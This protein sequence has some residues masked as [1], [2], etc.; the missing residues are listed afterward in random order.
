MI[1]STSNDVG[2]TPVRKLCTL[3]LACALAMA[4]CDTGGEP[5]ASDPFATPT[6]HVTSTS[7]TV[8]A[9]TT[10]L[11]EPE[12]MSAPFNLDYRQ[13]PIGSPTQ[14]WQVPIVLNN[15]DVNSRLIMEQFLVA[16]LSQRARDQFLLRGEIPPAR[17]VPTVEEVKALK[18]EIDA[19][20][21]VLHNFFYPINHPDYEEDVGFPTH[22]GVSPPTDVDLNQ[23]LALRRDPEPNSK[24][25]ILCCTDQ[26]FRFEVSDTGALQVFESSNY[27]ADVASQ[28]LGV[29][30]EL[31]SVTDSSGSHFTLTA[32]TERISYKFSDP[33]Q[34]TMDTAFFSAGGTVEVGGILSPPPSD[35]SLLFIYDCRAI[36]YQSW[37]PDDCEREHRKQCDAEMIV[38][39]F[40]A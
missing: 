7:S 12:F 15:P 5:T 40:T 39:G 38:C 9:T 14:W 16:V 31:L 36:N 23:G 21:G 4:G 35:T 22:L 1:D 32:H 2:V 30:L 34:A 6:F 3:Y 20:G 27:Q 26:Y 29:L 18:A 13:T 24:N 10:T 33:E 37:T 8:A 11:V 25:F 17:Y 19:N 28:V